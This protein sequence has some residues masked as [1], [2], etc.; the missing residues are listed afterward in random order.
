MVLIN[1]WQG[2]TKGRGDSRTAQALFRKRPAE[3]ALGQEPEPGIHFRAELVVGPK[4][5]RRGG[6]K[7]FHVQ[8]EVGQC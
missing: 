5:K 1:G 7:C 2:T 8:P 3:G 6:L 4:R